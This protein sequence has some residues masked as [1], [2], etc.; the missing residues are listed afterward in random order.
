MD[1]LNR[2]PGLDNGGLGN[3][4]NGIELAPTN[5]LGELIK[6]IP[7][8]LMDTVTSSMI[9]LTPEMAEFW[10]VSK[11]LGYQRQII[12]SNLNQ[13]IASMKQG[14]F[15]LTAISLCTVQGEDEKTVDGYHRVNSVWRSRT[16]Q[17]FILLH[18]DAI[19][20]DDRR[21]LYNYFDRGGKVRS[22]GQC[23]DTD[24]L[25]EVS[26]LKNP[27]QM[28]ELQRAIGIISSSFNTNSYKHKS[29]IQYTY[30]DRTRFVAQ[31]GH[32]AR[33]YFDAMKGC[34]KQ[35]RTIFM[36]SAVLSIGVVTFETAEELAGSF[37]RPI[38]RND[39]LTKGDPR[40]TLYQIL[41]N[42][43]EFNG[44]GDVN[45]AK[46][47]AVCWGSHVRGEQRQLIRETSISSPVPILRTRFVIGRDA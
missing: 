5:H 7:K 41:T 9:I 1:L 34:S 42:P 27:G 44:R 39:G 36:R 30:D 12:D 28:G 45:Y 20:E 21:T 4:H 32:P 38:A 37:W 3:G 23:V 16:N 19:S 2:R 10:K 26:G 35:M 31:Y 24:Y 47:I 13:M 22:W 29:S 40:H 17:K 46:K 14:A 8:Y 43:K 25:L 11:A 18:F 33:L 15:P 6:P